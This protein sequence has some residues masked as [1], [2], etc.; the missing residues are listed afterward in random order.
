MFHIRIGLEELM[1]VTAV[2]GIVTLLSFYRGTP[3]WLA[4]L[5]GAVSLTF[6]VLGS[7]GLIVPSSNSAPVEFVAWPNLACG[8]ICIVEAIRRRKRLRDSL[9]PHVIRKPHF[10]WDKWPNK[11]LEPTP[12]AVTPPANE[13][14]IE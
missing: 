9:K 7:L 6:G 4:V 10:G 5:A 3:S 11:A 12:T 1:V 2:G 8:L 14:R 13:S